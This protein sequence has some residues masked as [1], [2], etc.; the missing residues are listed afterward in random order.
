MKRPEGVFSMSGRAGRRLHSCSAGKRRLVV[1]RFDVFDVVWGRDW[2]SGG[3]A[4]SCGLERFGFWGHNEGLIAIVVLYGPRIND[5]YGTFIMHIITRL[6]S[7]VGSSPDQYWANGIQ[8]GLPWPAHARALADRGG[9]GQAAPMARQPA[10]HQ[11]ISPW[12]F[13][14]NLEYMPSWHSSQATASCSVALRSWRP[15]ARYANKWSWNCTYRWSI[16]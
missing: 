13:V 7:P 16:D 3:G 10:T 8:N 4:R 15:R 2:G 11:H 14:A 6:L 9:E 12:L 5:W 1:R